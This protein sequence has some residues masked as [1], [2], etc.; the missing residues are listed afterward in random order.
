MLTTTQ[1]R[2]IILSLESKYPVNSWKLNEIHLWPILRIDMFFFLLSKNHSEAPSGTEWRASSDPKHFIPNFLV[3]I[4]PES[5]QAKIKG[6]ESYEF[7]KRE[8]PHPRSPEAL[9][10]LA[11][12]WGIAHGV[13]LAEAFCIIRHIE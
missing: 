2:S 10:I 8:Y 12:R 9:E 1:I 5:L 6:M 7:E 13:Y 3:D 11:K 4:T